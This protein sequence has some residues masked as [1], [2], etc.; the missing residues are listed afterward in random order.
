MAIGILYREELKEYD[1]GPGHPF[2][3]DRYE[4]FPKFLRENLPQDKNYQVLTAEPVTNKDLVLICQKDYIDFTKKYFRARN[5]DQDFDGRFFQYH[6]MD[7]LPGRNP[8]KIETAGRIIVGQAKLACYLIQKGEFK[9]VISLGGGL[10][11]AKPSYGEGFCIYNDVAFAAKY[12]IKKYKL[13]RI[14]VLDTDAHCG[15]GT[16]EYFYRDPLTLYP[17]TGF[18]NQIGKAEGRGFTINVPLPIFAGYD[19]YQLVFEEIIEPVTKVLPY[20]W[21][22]LISGLA[23]FKIEIEEPIPISQR[24]QKDSLLEET[25]GVIRELKRN[26]KN[27]W[28]CF[29]M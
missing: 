27:Y 17:G 21:L 20:G 28:K 14:L 7:N 13:K 12:L 3:S 9:K 26:L 1:F 11:H 29:K 24:F 15:N 22:A 8:G 4:M 2:R 25:K 16:M 19:S 18:A 6:S 10:H 5:L 23:N